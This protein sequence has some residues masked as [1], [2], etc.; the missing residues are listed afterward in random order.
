LEAKG[1]REDAWSDLV[2]RYRESQRHYHTLS[3][4][5]MMFAEFTEFLKKNFMITNASAEVIEM[6][7]WF[8]DAVYD[9]KRHDNE[10]KSADLFRHF[11][12]RAGLLTNFCE[13]VVSAILATKH[14]KPLSGREGN[15]DHKILCDLDLTI[16]GQPED[17]FDRYESQIRQEYDWV[18][19]QDFVKGRSAVLQSFLDRK[20]IYS[21]KFFREK[22]QEQARRNLTRSIAQLSGRLQS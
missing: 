19:E 12:K 13:R 16:L 9:P 8:H 14:D 17:I 6:A 11:A 2:H 4:L 7:I 21:T 10:E 3:H 20:S 5:E 22:Y 18:P 15:R 1:S